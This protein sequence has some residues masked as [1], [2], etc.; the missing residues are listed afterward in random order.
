MT[1]PAQP[2]TRPVLTTIRPEYQIIPF[3]SDYRTSDTATSLSTGSN[4]VI[5][6]GGGCS[7]GVAAPGGQGTFYAGAIDAA[8]A[9]L[10]ANARPNTKNVMIILSDVT[11]VRARPRWAER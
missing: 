6:A 3:S 1:T 2:K 10:V 9:Q 5:T 8:Q 4:L 11:P 7:N